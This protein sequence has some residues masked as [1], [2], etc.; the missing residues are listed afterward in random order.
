MSHSRHRDTERGQVGVQRGHKTQGRGADAE[1]KDKAGPD[2]RPNRRRPLCPK[3]RARGQRAAA[4]W[5]GNELDGLKLGHRKRLARL[6]V[7]LTMMIL[8]PLRSVHDTFDDD[9]GSKAA[10]RLLDGDYL[11]PDAVRKTLRLACVRRIGEQALKRVLVLQDTTSFNYTT[12][13]AAEGLGPLG[14]SDGSGGAGFFCHSLFAV[15]PDGVPLGLIDQFVWAR[16]PDAEQGRDDR[17]QRPIEEKESHRWIRAQQVIQQAIPTDVEVV[18]IGDRESDIYEFLAEPRPRN[19]YYLIRACRE[20]CLEDDTEKLWQ[21]VRASDSIGGYTFKV[22]ELPRHRLRT[23]NVQVQM[24]TLT[25]KASTYGV[26]SDDAPSVRVTAIRVAE[27]D[28]PRKADAIDWLLLTN[29]PA[30][31]LDDAI[32]CVGYYAKRWIIERFHFVLKSGCGMERAQLRTFERL[33][34]LLV[35]Y[36][37][38]AYR[39][40]WM[41]Y[42]ARVDPDLP[43]TAVF[44]DA[45]WRALYYTTHD[46]AAPPDNPISLGHAIALLGALGGHKGRKCDGSPGAK[47]LWRGLSRLHQRIIGAATIPPEIAGKA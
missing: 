39:I 9:A 25:V 44:G 11:D 31:T 37:V 46:G 10:Y 30:T 6:I 23:V 22:R 45:E 34:R 8:R 3:R 38:V 14:D 42:L 7:V 21:K 32:E 36:S 27:I 1:A 5:V 29:L 43:C 28:P 13:R 18:T 4:R 17:R 33:H 40:M 24:M 2:K 16:D 19:A 15:T 47:V 12:R 35:L 41:L 26:R 20:R